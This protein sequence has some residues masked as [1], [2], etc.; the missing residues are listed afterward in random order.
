MLSIVSF[1]YLAIFTA[2]NALRLKNL[3]FSMIFVEIECGRTSGT[4]NEISAKSAEKTVFKVI[5]D[6]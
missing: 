2:K 6:G 4:S 3:D 5:S 1:N